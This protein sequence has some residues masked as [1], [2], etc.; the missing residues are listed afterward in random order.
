MDCIT[1]I[2]FYYVLNII[3][4][5]FDGGRELRRP[6]SLERPWLLS[7]SSVRLGIFD[8]A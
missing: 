2:E 7:G 1:I 3:S 6:I 8:I 4:H 5:E